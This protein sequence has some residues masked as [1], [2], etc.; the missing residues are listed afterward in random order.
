M[1]LSDEQLAG[2]IV[3]HAVLPVIKVLLE[4]DP[5][6]KKPFEGLSGIVQFRAQDTD[7]PVGA[8][9]VFDKGDFRVEQGIFE[10]KADLLFDFPSLKS[11]NDMFRG[12]PVL[13]RLGPL[14]KAIPGRFGL[15]LKTFKVLLAMKI[16]MPNTQPKTPEKAY[17][18]VKMSLY[19]VST[20]LSRMNKAGDPDMKAWTSKQPE[21]IYQWSVEGSDIACY[22]KVKA[23]NTK[24]GRGVYTRRQPFVHMRFSS[25]DNA[26]PV[27]SNS[28]DTV[29]AIAQGL[30]VNDGS[31]EYG[32]RVGD[33]ML[34]IAKLLS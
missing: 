18:K 2:K 4:D 12:K 31:P 7:T 17:L 25:V 21:R 6:F 20:A 13:P 16:L 34:R 30:L 3:L 24:A 29:T 23:G 1:T 22:L 19:M 26:L 28:V 8:Y 15:L 10:G 9:L 5:A 27:L 33:F 11:M 14:L 32:G